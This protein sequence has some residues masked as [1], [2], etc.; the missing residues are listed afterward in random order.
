MFTPANFNAP[1]ATAVSP[2]L[3]ES[4]GPATV[5]PT[6][7]ESPSPSPAPTP[8]PRRVSTTFLLLLVNSLIFSAMLVHS[9]YILSKAAGNTFVFPNF[10]SALLRSWG[11]NYGPLTLTGQFWRVITST[12]VH[13][14][15]YHLACNMLFLWGLGRY[16]DRLFTRAQAFAIYLLTGAAGNIFSLAWD[17][18]RNSCGASGAIYGQ[19]GVL[20]TLLCFA[21]LN[22]PRRDIRNLLLWIV[23][24][25]PIELLWS[26]LS[27]HT[28]YAGHAGGILAGLVI[29][30]LLAPMF[31]PPVAR[32]GRQYQ[33][34]RLAAV[35]LTIIF[36]IVIQ[37]RRN[38]ALV[39]A[40]IGNLGF[41]TPVN[42]QP[43]DFPPQ[44]NTQSHLPGPPP[45][46]ARVF[47]ALKGDPKLVHYFSGL[48]NAE[49][50]NAGIAVAGS[51]HDAEGVLRGEVKAQSERVNLSMGVVKM[52]INSQHGFQTIDFC[53]TLSTSESTNLY[54]RSAASA[55]SKIRAKY[56][57]ART[58]RLDPASDLA[59][60][61]QFAAEFQS[62]LKT[63]G[64]TMVQSGPADIALHIDLRTEKIPVEE[65]E[66]VYNIK[67][68]APNG[69][70]LV[71]SSGSGVL[72]AR[73]VGN[74]PAACPERLADLEWIYNT[75]TLYSTAHK[76]TRDLNQQPQP[77]AAK[78]ASKPK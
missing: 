12:F 40:L 4:V 10:D 15:F 75:D 9:D 35:A 3:Q 31:R 77:R 7:Q 27:K 55:V 14:N 57:D 44:A 78:P 11:S 52:Y 43:L 68:V 48:L 61:Q 46:I 29:G 23:F 18:I 58:V 70:Q 63:S 19:A 47:L 21:R 1:D 33:V 71:Q 6:L 26:P 30:A 67:V 42:I 36:T 49:L 72:S 32:A 17:P 53:K 76:V 25:M 20:I 39:Y 56:H 41:R 54:E 45:R 59:A 62:E 37:V 5:T 69:V 16:L 60:S 24:L 2:A 38:G 51:E 28:D 64:L 22:L 50:E 74:A 34:L 66:A 65:D 13:L 73:L 8:H